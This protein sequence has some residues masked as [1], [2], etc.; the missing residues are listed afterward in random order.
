[1]E[2]SQLR[3]GTELFNDLGGAFSVF[4]PEGLDDV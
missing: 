4:V 2:L 1:M 3:I